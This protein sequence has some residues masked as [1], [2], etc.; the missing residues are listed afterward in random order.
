ML[1]KVDFSF[2]KTDMVPLQGQFLAVILSQTGLVGFLT[3]RED[4]FSCLG[5]ICFHD[6]HFSGFLFISAS[7]MSSIHAF[8]PAVVRASDPIYP[9]TNYYFCS[10]FLRFNRLCRNKASLM[11]IIQHVQTDKCFGTLKTHW[12][13]VLFLMKTDLINSLMYFCA[14]LVRDRVNRISMNKRLIILQRYAK[15]VWTD[16]SVLSCLRSSERRL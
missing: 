15:V 6:L 5:C 13:K 8:L 1:F 3:E 11:E 2:E 9:S 10:F 7:R 16:L 4:I 12:N 14:A